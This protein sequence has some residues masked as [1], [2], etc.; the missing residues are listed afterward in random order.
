LPDS[1]RR[2]LEVVSVAGKPLPLAL[3]GEAAEVAVGEP[4]ATRA[5]WT[6]LRSRRLI[7]RARRAGQD[8]IEPYHDRVRETVAGRLAPAV[9]RKHHGRQAEVLEAGGQA[10]P[11]TLAIHFHGA[12]NSVR[13]ARYHAL[14]GDQAAETLAF[15]HA[16][17]LYGLA[18]ELGAWPGAE[19]AALHAKR[20]DA[21]ANAGRGPE[22]AETYLRAAD[23]SDPAR[24]MELRRRAAYQYCASGHTA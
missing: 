24:A 10:D 2:L 18:L 5:T 15:D 7:G 1:A 16:A 23:G 17:R 12:G 20:G 3:A 9:L 11:E 8:V 13:A 4:Q 21:L 14:G 6:T 19:A 22:S